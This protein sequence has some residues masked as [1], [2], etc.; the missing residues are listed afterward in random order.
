[1]L[2]AA[3]VLPLVGN[4]LRFREVQSALCAT[5]HIFRRP[6]LRSIGGGGVLEKAPQHVDRQ[7]YGNSDDDKSDQV[8]SYIV[9]SGREDGLPGL[10][11]EPEFTFVLLRKIEA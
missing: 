3:K 11:A 9:W 10:P 6:C 7:P 1:M 2:L 5:N 4:R 8:H